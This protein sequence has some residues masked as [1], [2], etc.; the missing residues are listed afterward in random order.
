MGLTT[1][2]LATALAAGLLAVSPAEACP[3]DVPPPASG[4]TLTVGPG[5]QYSTVQAAADAARPGDNVSIA[6]GTY[7]G[8]LTLKQ[9]GAP[10]KY[11]TFYG[12]GGTAVIQGK[13]GLALGDRSWLRFT[14]VTVSGSSRF[15][16][17]A[18]QAHDLVFQKFGIDGSQ[19]GGLVLLDTANAVIDGCDI[20]GTN[21]RGTSADHEAMSLGE[22]SRDIEVKHCRVHDNGEEGID[23][24]YTENARISIHDNVSSNNRGPNIYVDS[25]SGVEIYN[26]VASGT[27]NNTKA[28]IALAVEDYS[29]SR[30]LDNVKVY[31]N[32][33][34]G[35]SQA[36]LSIWVESTGVISNVRIINNTFYGNAQ[37]AMWFGGDEYA[38]VNVLRNNIYAEGNFT[39]PAFTSDHNVAGDPGFVDP[40][41]GDFHLRPGSAKAVD[42]GSATGAP[43]FD[44]D[45]KPRPRG[46]GHDIGAYEM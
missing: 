26:N 36:G 3:P 21:A 1:T 10:G 32:V 11:I 34:Y 7:P 37:G 39:H 5:G 25:S 12:Q 45:N 20:R 28:G 19:D 38:G 8:G 29:E 4:R 27:K 31:N 2:A 24:K 44:L 16:V 6:A 41:A 33:S 17:Y 22:G 14:N 35:N 18:Y 15:G 23:V 30:K 40:R 9:S 46:A 42:R 43:A 13:D